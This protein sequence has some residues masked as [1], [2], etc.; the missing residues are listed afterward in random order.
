MLKK[1]EKRVS[2]KQILLILLIIF[3]S[4]VLAIL[5]AAT[6]YIEN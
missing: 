5:I 3:L 6:A 4:V 2:V 1:K